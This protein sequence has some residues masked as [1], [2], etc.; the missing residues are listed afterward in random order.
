MASVIAFPQQQQQSLPI[1]SAGSGSGN[2]DSSLLSALAAYVTTGAHARSTTEQEIHEL[3]QESL[4]KPGGRAHLEALIACD[5]CPDHQ[6]WK[7]QASADGTI[8]I[9]KTNLT[10]SLGVNTLEL[11]FEASGAGFFVPYSGSLNV[12]VCPVHGKT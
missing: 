11:K 1:Q 4:S 2:V 5:Q 7:N 10:I 3:A 8:N 12:L 9:T 6:V